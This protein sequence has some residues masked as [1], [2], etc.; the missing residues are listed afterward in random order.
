VTPLVFPFG[1]TERGPDDALGALVAKTLL[2]DRD[3][4]D[5]L[6]DGI[7]LPRSDEPGLGRLEAALDGCREALAV[8]AT[9]RD[10]VR[11]GRLDPAPGD[12]LAAAA[13]RAGILTDR[14]LDLLHDADTARA[15]A[16]RV[17]AFD[18]KEF[19]S[20]R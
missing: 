8:E 14:D 20:G 1:R 12:A 19:R 16:I 4:R 9:L 3:A 13:R 7:F 2:D 11:A 18:A 17:D 6:T 10:A 5:R 15:E